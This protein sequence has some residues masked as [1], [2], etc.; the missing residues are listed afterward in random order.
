MSQGTVVVQPKQEKDFTVGTPEEFVRRFGGTRVINKVKC[1]VLVESYWTWIMVAELKSALC[2]MFYIAGSYCKQWDCCC[3]MHAFYSPLV[4]WDVQKWESCS[5]CCHGH[6][7]G[8]ERYT[9]FCHCIC[10][11]IFSTWGQNPKDDYHLNGTHCE[12]PNMHMNF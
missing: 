1:Y 3:Q 12:I 6:P 9:V 2:T 11:W 10:K 7:R 5:I 4:L 8:F